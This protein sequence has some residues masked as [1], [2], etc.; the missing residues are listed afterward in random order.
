MTKG[1]LKIGNK[2]K[3]LRA[4]NLCI[5]DFVQMHSVFLGIKL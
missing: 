1:E 5:Q 4:K 3:K 2:K